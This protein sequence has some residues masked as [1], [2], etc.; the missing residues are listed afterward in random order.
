MRRIGVLAI[1]LVGAVLPAAVAVAQGN[2]GFPLGDIVYAHGVVQ[3]RT[4]DHGSP[5]SPF[6]QVS[7]ETRDWIAAE[8]KRQIDAPRTPDEVASSV[9]TALVEDE[10][11]L[12]KSYSIDPA[13]IT[14]AITLMI[15][16]DAEDGAS[17]LVRQARKSGDPVAAQAAAEKAAHATANRKAAVKMQSEVSMFLATL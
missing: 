10:M 1:V 14:K 7:K 8:T 9:D 17:R 15:M 3:G 6:S 4:Q 13:D 11:R 16:A 12:S 5:D 2:A